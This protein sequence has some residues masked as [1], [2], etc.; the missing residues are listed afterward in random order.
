MNVSAESLPLY[1]PI[2]G[3]YVDQHAAD[4][5]ANVSADMSTNISRYIGRVSVDMW[6]DISVDTSVDYRL[7]GAQNTLDPSL[8]I[9][10][11]EN[12]LQMCQK[13]IGNIPD[14]SKVL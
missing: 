6:T 4:T 10:K 7:R 11:V 2:V 3:Q 8:H 1:W 12:C 13:V 14:P 9:Y 5:T